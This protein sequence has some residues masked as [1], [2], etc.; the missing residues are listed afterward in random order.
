MNK[1]MKISTVLTASIAL[2]SGITTV[3]QS[4]TA[5]ATKTKTYQVAVSS[6]SRP[7][8]YEQNGQLKGYEVEALRK[9]DQ[10]LPDVKFKYHAVSQNAELVGLD[11]G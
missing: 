11:S 10:Q 2:F 8:S 7:L 3:G 4:A 9:I 5:H 1:L 6:S